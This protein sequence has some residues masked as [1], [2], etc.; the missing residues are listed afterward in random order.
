MRKA[1]FVSALLLL[2]ACGLA[3]SASAA[4]ADLTPADPRL[5]LGSLGIP[6]PTF[7]ASCTVY[8]NPDPYNPSAPR[9]SCSSSTGNCYHH[10]P[11]GV[12]LL[13]CDGVTY[14]CPTYF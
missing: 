7:M 5:D 8:C 6:Q 11:K 13:T 14:A 4:A 10:T 3:W 2:T 9:M 12:E 1:F